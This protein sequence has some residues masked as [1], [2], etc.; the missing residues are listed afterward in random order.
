MFAK[1]FLL[2]VTLTLS[3]AGTGW[4]QSATG[5]NFGSIPSGSAASRSNSGLSSGHSRHH[6][7]GDNDQGSRNNGGGGSGRE[8]DARDGEGAAPVA[9]QAST[10]QH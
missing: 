2:S 4:A 8:I 7:S 1:I 10:P 3:A 9:H 6:D 5:G